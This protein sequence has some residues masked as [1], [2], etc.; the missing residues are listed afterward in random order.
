MTDY[1]HTR[2]TH[3]ESLETGALAL[4]HVGDAVFELLVRGYLCKKGGR[5]AR[6]LHKKT[7]AMVS[8]NAQAK[9]MERLLPILTEHEAEIYHRGRN[10]KVHSVPKGAELSAY[11]AATGL[12]CLFGTLYL[13]GE[14]DRINLLFDKIVEEENGFSE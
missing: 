13:A 2:L 11:H 3:Q 8:A 7:V 10:T 9:A 5:S 14:Y 4:A 12:E 1:L 6:T